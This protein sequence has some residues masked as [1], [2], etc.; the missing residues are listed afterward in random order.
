MFLRNAEKQVTIELAVG[1][2]AIS[3]L[4]FCVSRVTDGLAPPSQGEVYTMAK[5]SKAPT[6][7]EV[8]GEISK[9]TGLSRKQVSSVFESLSGVVKKSLS[10][11]GPGMFT[12]PGLLK[13]RVIHK[14]ATP[15]R[16]GMDPFTKQE[17]VFKAKPARNVVRI[18]P[19]K[20]LKDMV[21]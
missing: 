1:E 13:I 7:S 18:R 6:K 15:E 19:L 14:P 3:K 16:K 10:K 5:N 9:V 4:F 11:K 21:N 8:Y 12:V 2:T 17:R 20:A